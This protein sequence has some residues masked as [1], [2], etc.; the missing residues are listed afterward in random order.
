MRLIYALKQELKKT[1]V[2]TGFFVCVLITLILFLLTTC[3]VDVN[4]GKSYSVIETLLFIKSNI[5]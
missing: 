5:L 3:Y 2:N 4:T 1:V